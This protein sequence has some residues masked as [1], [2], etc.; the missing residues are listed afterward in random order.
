MR[1]LTL[2]V[3]FVVGCSTGTTPFVEQIYPLAVQQADG[4]A[5]LVDLDGG[6]AFIANGNPGMTGLTG[7]KG[8][9]GETGLQGIA[10]PVG[11]VGPQGPQGLTPPSPTLYTADGGLIGYARWEGTNSQALRNVYLPGVNCLGEILWEPSTDGGSQIAPI[12]D[13]ILF[14]GPNCSGA[15]FVL[16]NAQLFPS[17]CYQEANDQRGLTYAAIQPMRPR[18]FVASSRMVL[19]NTPPNGM[20]IQCT[21][22]NSNGVGVEVAPVTINPVQFPISI[23]LR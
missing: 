23:G 14:E 7:P 17:G 16:S 8:E 6:R 5:W 11:P 15:T 1:F 2:G 12:R 13:A 21:P 20:V 22:W 4:G 10:G 19:F 3:L 18:R 9:R